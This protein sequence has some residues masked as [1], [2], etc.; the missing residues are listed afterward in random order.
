MTTE[1]PWRNL[2]ENGLMAVLQV[3]FGGNIKMGLREIGCK[4]WMVDG[5]G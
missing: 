3:G 2:F 1:L 4:G 5:S